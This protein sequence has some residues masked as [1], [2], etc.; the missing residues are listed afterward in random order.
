MALAV[1]LCGRYMTGDDEEDE[2]IIILDPAAE[3]LTPLA[4]DMFA[5]GGRPEE[6]ARLPTRG[7]RHGTWCVHFNG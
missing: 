2:P 3:T 1:V 7:V 4:R 6:H 5:V